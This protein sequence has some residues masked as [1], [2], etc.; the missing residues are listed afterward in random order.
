MKNRLTRKNK[1]LTTIEE[2]TEEEPSSGLA[3]MVVI[4]L[5]V[6]FLGLFSQG[7]LAENTVPDVNKTGAG[8]IRVVDHHSSHH[9]DHQE[10]SIYF[11]KLREAQTQWIESL[12]YQDYGQEAFEKIFLDDDTLSST[13]STNKAFLKLKSFQSVSSSSTTEGQDVDISTQ[14]LR[15][16]LKIK[17]LQHQLYKNATLVWVTGGHSAAAGHGNLFNESYTAFLERDLSRIAKSIGLPLEVRN[18]AMGGSGSGPEL[19]LCVEQ[20]YG[21][22]VD[23]LS[24]DF[25]MTDVY[26]PVRLLLYAIR[27]NLLPH[28]PAI[29]AL[30]AEGEHRVDL[31]KQFEE[32]SAS[33][34][35]LPEDTRKQQF[36][37]IPE[38]NMDNFKEMQDLPPMINSFK[39]TEGIEKGDL[40]C[41]D[42][43]YSKGL[44]D[45][46]AGKASWHPGFK[47]H[48]LDGH[49]IA[50]FVVQELIHAA[51]EL[52]VQLEAHD[53]HS[54]SDESVEGTTNETETEPTTETEHHESVVLEPMDLLN[55]L[56]AKE[57]EDFET[58]RN[59][60]LPELAYKVHEWHKC[61]KQF[62][63][64]EQE[65]E[66][67]CASDA[68]FDASIV[69]TFSKGPGICHTARLPSET[70]YKGYLTN[71]TTKVGGPVPAGKETYDTGL[72]MDVNNIQFDGTLKLVYKPDQRAKD[73]SVTVSPDYKDFFFAH[74]KDDWAK[75]VIPNQAEKVAYDY[76]ASEFKG[77]IGIAFLTCPWNRCPEGFLGTKRDFD[78]GKFEITVNGVAVTSLMLFH[79][80][81]T[82]FLKGSDGFQWKYREGSED[83]EIAIRILEEGSHVE[84][85]SFILY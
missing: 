16:K 37:G 49:T 51:E 10:F 20:I 72:S 9:A 11:D 66:K 64:E 68:D 13:V 17:L 43:K 85:S 2:G 29:F 77:L 3:K 34:F 18:F 24:W 52:A 69:K 19:G 42:A 23:L 76:K 79:D 12:L 36:E 80:L 56:M 83:Y 25:G 61:G 22:D 74:Q 27:G 50:L 70:R 6:V 59:A 44:C 5:V 45:S 67:E 35:Y 14:R 84:V 62:S 60:E 65:L 71:D 39:C 1:K 28:H 75:I 58:F 32:M 46:R 55:I 40:G 26:S 48:A 38:V 78:Q 82:Y 54:A 31:L 21:R 57:Q 73:C 41:D 15:R 8:N 63:E 53:S 81:G 33:A 7:I 47:M 4:A 30:H